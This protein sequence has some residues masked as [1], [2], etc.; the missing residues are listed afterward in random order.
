MPNNTLIWPMFGKRVIG[1]KLSYVLRVLPHECLAASSSTRAVAP[2]AFN[3][4][5]EMINTFHTFNYNTLIRA[6][7]RIRDSRDLA[8]GII[9]FALG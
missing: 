2:R 1:R 6:C 8:N 4:P 7:A 3:G 5:R 9:S